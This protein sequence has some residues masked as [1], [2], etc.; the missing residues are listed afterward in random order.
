LTLEGYAVDSCRFF[1]QKKEEVTALDF[2]KLYAKKFVDMQVD[3]V[4]NLIVEFNAPSS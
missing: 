3:E 1:N 2:F 4:S